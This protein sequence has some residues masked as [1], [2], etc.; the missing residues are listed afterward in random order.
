[1]SMYDRDDPQ[2]EA[3][4]SFW[5][6]KLPR[7]R[8]PEPDVERVMAQTGMGE[9]QAINHLK[10]RRALQLRARDARGGVL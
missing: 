8:A 6:H 4:A 10:Q 3:Y 7:D 2:H 5:A 1:M 9:I